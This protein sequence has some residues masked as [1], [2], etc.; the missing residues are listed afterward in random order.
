MM[1]IRRMIRKK[2]AI[3]RRMRMTMR[4]HRNA[5]PQEEACTLRFTLSMIRTSQVNNDVDL[6]TN[7]NFK[8]LCHVF[9]I[10]RKTMSVHI[11]S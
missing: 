5:G 4:I 11:F 2:Y 10:R 1:M 3:I 7:N 9:F 6:Y 8:I